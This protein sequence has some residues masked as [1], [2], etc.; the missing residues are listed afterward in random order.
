M[1]NW[2]LL[3]NF[4]EVMCQDE[5]FGEK[6]ISHARSNL[7]AN[8]MNDCHL[9]D[10]GYCGP[11]YTW[12]NKRKINPI[13]ERLDRGWANVDWLKM[14]PNYSLRHLPRATSD[15]YPLLLNLLPNNLVVGEKPFRFE[16]MYWSQTSLMW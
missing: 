3:G 10:I 16:P 13:Y 6:K 5:N 12:T 7:Y 11:K 2:V 4:N 15:H 1:I 14:F 8:T 9:V